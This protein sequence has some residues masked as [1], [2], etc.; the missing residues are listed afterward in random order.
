MRDLKT[1]TYQTTGFG[2]FTYVELPDGKNMLI[3]TGVN[4]FQGGLKLEHQLLDEVG[5]LKEIDYLILTN[6]LEYRC[7]GVSYLNGMYQ[8]LFKVNNFYYIDTT[9]TTQSVST[10][11]TDAKNILA[12]KSGCE[13]YAIS[14]NSDFTINFKEQGKSQVYSYAIDFTVAVTPAS[15]T[16]I[17]D[18]Q[19]Y[20]SITYIDK[21]ILLAGDA[22]HNNI[23]GYISKTGNIDVDVL[24]TGFNGTY[25]DAISNSGSSGRTQPAFLTKINLSEGDYAIITWISTVYIGDLDDALYNANTTRYSFASLEQPRV[26]TTITK[27]GSLNVAPSL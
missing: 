9:G 20:V 1:Y 8:E 26:I 18:N 5:N 6:A 12:Q 16:N 15:A 10:E 27:D 17:F 13:S 2:V 3:D 14:D 11:F 25:F 22:T 24:V 23:D 7:G 4:S 21:T 19:V